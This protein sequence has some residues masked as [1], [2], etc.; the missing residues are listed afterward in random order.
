M[1]QELAAATAEPSAVWERMV[2]FVRTHGDDPETIDL[3][4]GWLQEP[5]RCR[6]LVSVLGNSPYLSHVFLRWPDFFATPPGSHPQR[7]VDGHSLTGALLASNNWGEAS[8]LLR[9]HKHRW[10]LWIGSRD[11]TGEAGLV[12]TIRSLSDLADATLEAG[13]RWLDRRLAARF[14]QP[15]VY[16][17]ESGAAVPVPFV[18]LGM[19]KLGARELNFSSDID[20]IYL[21]DEKQG[22]VEGSCTI[23]L[24]DYFNRLGRDLIKLLGE[25]TADGRVFRIDLRLRPEGES[26]TLSLSRRSAEVYYESW[27]RTWERA[28]MIK[29]R[30]VAGD[31]AM[32]AAFLED[33][34]PFVYRRYLDF[35]ALDAIRGM[36]HKIDQKITRAAD[37][38]RNIKL[39]Y[40]GIREIEFFVQCQQLIHGGKDD[41]LRHRETLTMLKR[42]VAAGWLEAESAANLENAYHFLR[43]VE[44]RLQ[45]VREQQVHSL[46]EDAES[47]AALAKRMGMATAA[48]LENRLRR[49]TDGVHRIYGALFHEAQRQRE[50]AS[51]PL[52]E[53]ILT[54]EPEE[55]RCLT[56]LRDAGFQEPEL[57]QRLITL[58]REGPSRSAIT[59]LARGWYGRIG[60]PFLREILKAPDQDMAIRHAEDF[61]NALGHRVSYLA[62]LLENPRVLH[63]LIRLFG[64]SSLLSRFFIQ[65]PELMDRLVTRDFLER[66][67][68]RADLSKDLDELLDGA[69]DP[70]TRFDLIREF[71]N[72]ETLRMGVRDLSGVA[73]LAEIMSGLS[74]LA[75]VVL[76]RVLRDA[77]TELAQRFGEPAWG[78]G[79]VRHRAP[80]VILAMGKLGGRE[81]NYSSDL[82]LI[83][84]H[85]GEGDAQW[86]D[87]ARSI[88][89]N[90]FFTRLGQRIITS[91]TTLTR[92]GKLY[93]LDMRLRPSG[94]SGPLVSHIQAFC[95]YQ[96][97]EAW[98]WEHQAL[99]RARVVAGDAELAAQLKKEIRGII[100]QHRDRDALRREV[101]D[102][103]RRMYEEKKPQPGWLDI[104]QSRGGIV[105][106][107]FLTQFLILGH[108]TDHADVIQ[109]NVSSA[110]M[111]FRRVGLLDEADFAILDENYTFFR[112]VENRLRLLHDR[113]ENRIGPDP[114]VRERLRRLCDLEEGADLVAILQDRFARVHA[115]YRRFLEDA[116]EIMESSAEGEVRRDG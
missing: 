49:V 30:A 115:I 112:L 64:S 42:L 13:Y 52:V 61:L 19:G 82:D 12:E 66:Y 23:S 110:L 65:H 18:V 41:R 114:R 4:T 25:A 100:A 99:T 47:F 62:L 21:Y 95:D 32:G 70:E 78:D 46:P 107:E 40:G 2:D 34:R 3:F 96:R 69:E 91:I 71:K 101:A 92:G 106:V 5:K 1:I 111:I 50:E 15:M 31:L 86:T 90:Q 104:K 33:L 56:L 81:L 73:E 102:M 108:A 87:G 44:H 39:G 35:G 98:V 84:I 88:N 45:I 51:D 68:N 29:A 113:S 80:F 89:N 59:E 22:L 83:Y 37:Y 79:P 57:A 36:K 58:L 24:N 60:A 26:G 97:Q 93:E 53:T 94:K 16:D 67:R 72:S 74:A 77:R 27:G 54:C 43:T 109:S 75:D 63:L 11:L 8:R 6:S 48:Q 28:A 76:G 103:R 20:L 17:E 105:D 14:G 10:F 38:H 7:L 9:H 85:G 116:P 55:A